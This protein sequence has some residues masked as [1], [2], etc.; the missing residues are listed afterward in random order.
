MLLS[1]TNRV[2]RGADHVGNLGHSRS[3]HDAQI[4]RPQ[5]PSRMS[6]PE[7]L[8]YKHEATTASSGTHTS[9]SKSNCGN[10]NIIFVSHRSTASNYALEE[11]EP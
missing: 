7:N 5:S 10:S 1:E 8:G 3:A 9:I 2:T 6:V 11:E 4:A